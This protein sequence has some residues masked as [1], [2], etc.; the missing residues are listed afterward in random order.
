MTSGF[1]RPGAP[2][3]T[4]MFL[5]MIHSAPLP[6]PPPHPLLCVI[7]YWGGGGGGGGGGFKGTRC[8]VRAENQPTEHMGAG[9]DRPHGE[10]HPALRRRRRDEFPESELHAGRGSQDILDE[11]GLGSLGNV[12]GSGRAAQNRGQ[13]RR[14]QRRGG[15]GGERKAERSRKASPE[16]GLASSRGDA[17]VRSFKLC[18]C[19]RCRMRCRPW[20]ARGRRST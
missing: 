18:V 6:P 2:H 3:L 14:G 13:G 4:R 5:S 19:V 11:S 9:A 1:S 7:R 16:K 15:Q 10:H 8:V 12:Q 20:R 17:C